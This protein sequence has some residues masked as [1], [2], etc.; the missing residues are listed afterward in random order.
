MANDF[1]EDEDMD[2]DFDDDFDVDNAYIPA[3]KA[4]SNV[5][6]AMLVLSAIF[7]IIALM[8][9]LLEL[10]PYTIDLKDWKL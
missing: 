10:A 6:T 9:T 2:M 7:Y 8:A 3:P 5:Y 4:K 1:D